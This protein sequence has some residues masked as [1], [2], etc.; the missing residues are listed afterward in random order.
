MDVKEAIKAIKDNYPD[1]GYSILRDGL[2]LAIEV[3]EKQIPKQVSET[4][5]VYKNDLDGYCPTCSIYITSEYKYCP[6]CGQK[7]DWD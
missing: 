7:L 5:V 6:N 4:E 1:S 3:L 2:N